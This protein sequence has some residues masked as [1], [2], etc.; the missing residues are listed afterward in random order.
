MDKKAII[1]LLNKYNDDE[2]FYKRCY[3]LNSDKKEQTKYIASFDPKELKKRELMLPGKPNK[4]K[5]LESHLFKEH[6]ANNIFLVKHNR[7]TPSFEH[8]HDFFEIFF[9]YSG[10]CKN[11]IREESFYMPSGSLCF[12]AP[13]VNHTLEV[14]ND[15]VIINILIRKTTFD[16]IFFNLLVTGDILSEFFLGSI[17]TVKSSE[18]PV[19]YIIFNLGDDTEMTEKIHEMLIE[20]FNNDKYSNRIMYNIISI[21]FTLLVRKYAD[22]PFLQHT[23]NDTD[24]L[25]Y[26]T[27]L[28]KN[29]RTVTLEQT[30]KHFSISTAHC[31]RLIKTQTGKCFI[32]I[33]RD[34]RLR[35]AQSLLK[36]TNMKINDISYSLGYE[37]Q[38][39]F[40]RS[41]KKIFGVTP[42]DYRKSTKIN[43][44]LE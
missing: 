14:F 26:I 29:F 36:S 30:A 20:Q 19:E 5:L 24:R 42:G 10:E 7:Y 16:E 6:D 1:S 11:T 2:I 28:N 33:V 25:R 32:D 37:N 40:I 18:K 13:H 12:I 22:K 3:E 8:S 38:E 4:L 34:I 27:Y 17:Y 35:H 21:F 41:F 15:S 31:S 23:G 43:R 39:T 9:V 44:V